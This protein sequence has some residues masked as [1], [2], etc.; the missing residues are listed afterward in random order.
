M[1]HVERAVRSL[2]AVL[3]FATLT[4]VSVAQPRA[5]TAPALDP[6]R[7]D[8]LFGAFTER[9]P[10]CAAAVVRDGRTL[11]ARGFGLADLSHRAP[12]GPDTVFEIAS[13]SKQF[14]AVA[15]LLLEA[16]GKLRLDDS[17]Q[18]HLP[19]VARLFA[20]PVSL[21]QLLH[22]TGGLVGYQELMELAGVAYENVVRPADVLRTIA[23][24]PALHSPPGTRHSYSDTGYFLLAQ[25]VARLG[26]GSLDAFLQKRV[27][28]PL[29]MTSTYVY[30]DHRR[31]VPRR[32]R[33]YEPIVGQQAWKLNESNWV[34]DGDAGVH[35]TVLDLARWSAEVTRPRVLP[36][37]V[38]EMLRTPG[39]LNDGSAMTYG[40]G[41]YVRPYRELPRALH[42]GAWVGYRAMLMHFPTQDAS[43]AV[44]CNTADAPAGQLAQR[45]ADEVLAHALAPVP[46]VAAAG[47]AAPDVAAAARYEGQ[48]LHEGGF[49]IVR[50]TASGPG[51]LRVT[52]QL[53]GSPSTGTFRPSP[54]GGWQSASGMVYLQLDDAG[55]TLRM[56]SDGRPTEA[57]RR[58]AAFTPSA[59]DLA[60]LTGRFRQVAL[61]SELVVAKTGNGLSAQFNPPVGDVQPLQW[62]GPD[63]L[64]HSDYLLRIERDAQGKVTALVYNR[65]RL[66]GLRYERQP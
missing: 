3:A 61:G 9:T 51:T 49:E 45:M 25:V 47:E 27:F 62:V 41:Q 37:A 30:N 19:E 42:S 23:I 59:A 21:R 18:Q 1:K 17:V 38:L 15:V 55:Q 64:A 7:I 56:K 22:H 31:V 35:S 58:A 44:L 43:V 53:D 5:G 39:R 29:G 2:L 54:A 4:G 13:I 57:Y 60:A 66:R 10:G 32:A 14:T 28:G 65:E 11:Y 40:M 24:L 6:A 20:Q 46:A 12:I 33:A 36:P 63:H 26:G 16:D 52:V 50:I 8:A 48:F 34:V